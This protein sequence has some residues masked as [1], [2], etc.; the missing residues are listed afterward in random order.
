MEREVVAEESV[1]SS[2]FLGF[3]ALLCVRDDIMGGLN[4]GNLSEF[5]IFKPLQISNSM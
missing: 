2:L 5:R 3:A 4:N 1:I